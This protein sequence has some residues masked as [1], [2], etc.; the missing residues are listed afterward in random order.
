VTFV[1]ADTGY[2]YTDEDLSL[3]DEIASRSAVAIEN[4]RL[5]RTAEE[6]NRAK[7]VFLST[8]SHELRTPLNAISGYAELLAMEVKDPLTPGQREQ[9]ERIRTNQR[10][11]L[12]LVNE[13]LDYAK[14]DVGRM[15]YDIQPVP[16]SAAIRDVECVVAPLAEAKQIAFPRECGHANL[17]VRAD[18]EKLTQIL[19][20]LF[21]NAVKFT[22]SGGRV[23]LQCEQEDGRIRFRIQDTGRGIPPE[24]LEHIFKPFIQVSEGLTR[25]EEGTGLGLAISRSLARGMGGEIMAQSV[26]GK[27][28][29]FTLDLPRADDARL[30]AKDGVVPFSGIEERHAE[31]E[32]RSGKERRSGE[33]RRAN[34]RENMPP[35]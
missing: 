16:V 25:T 6:A 11:L 18:R 26:L 21:T 17:V 1:S 20:N 30:E 2:Q 5:L 7:S 35:A 3:A 24:H 22:E 10:H 32:Q 28:S 33:D 15:E 29:I 13:V 8:M 31:D 9:I 27:G 4:A 12:G 23:T 34:E 14:L 19:V